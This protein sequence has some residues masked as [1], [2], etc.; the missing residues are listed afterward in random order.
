MKHRYL[1]RRVLG[2][3]VLLL[4]VASAYWWRIGREESKTVD[5]DPDAYPWRQS[6]V[7]GHGLYPGKMYGG[8]RHQAVIYH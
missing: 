7:N 5:T 6:M 2:I 8:F 1:Q 4:A 3:A